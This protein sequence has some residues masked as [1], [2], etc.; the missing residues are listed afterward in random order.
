MHPRYSDGGRTFRRSL[1][2]STAPHARRPRWAW[3][4]SLSLL[5]TL[6]GSPAEAAS[7]YPLSKRITALQWDMGSYQYSGLDGDIWP[8]TWA[9]D[10]RVL[11]AWGDGQL[12]CPA[13]ASYGV[14]AIG[15]ELPGTEMTAVHCGP[16]PLDLGKMMSLI[17]TPWVLAFSR[18]MSAR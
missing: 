3:L 4:G 15:T 8:M 13:K 6:L 9:A 16:G 18:S 10:G 1:T 7:P 5:A 2:R 17:A 12:V 14:A 11:G